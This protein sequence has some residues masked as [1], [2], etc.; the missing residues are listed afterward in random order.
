LIYNDFLR[1][2][3]HLAKVEVASSSLVS[4]SISMTYETRSPPCLGVLNT[5]L[6]KPRQGC[7]LPFLSPV[8]R[9]ACNGPWIGCFSSPL[10]SGSCTGHCRLVYVNSRRCDADR[11]TSSPSASLLERLHSAT[12]C[13]S[14]GSKVYQYGLAADPPAQTSIQS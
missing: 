14:L 11:E 13:S 12:L 7:A 10:I 6:T 9:C 2:D 5:T 3:H 1:D 4:R 8:L